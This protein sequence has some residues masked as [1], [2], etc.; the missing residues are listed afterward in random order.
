[1][2]A[3]VDFSAAISS[4]G[5][6][7]AMSASLRQQQSC[8]SAL[9]SGALLS[10]GNAAALRLARVYLP[11]LLRNLARAPNRQRKPGILP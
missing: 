5:S 8:I 2:L 6:L 10:P 3:S 9:A 7:P 1:M 4:A 11:W